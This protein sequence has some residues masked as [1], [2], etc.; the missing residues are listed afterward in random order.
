MSLHFDGHNPK[1]LKL[2]RFSGNAE[3]PPRQESVVFLRLRF[4]LGKHDDIVNVGSHPLCTV[5]QLR[6]ILSDGDAGFSHALVFPRVFRENVVDLFCRQ[7]PQCFVEET[8]HDSHNVNCG[9]YVI[10]L[11]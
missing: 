1:N 9:R 4:F 3:F 10:G 5:A 6:L 7:I 8:G 2:E 11:S